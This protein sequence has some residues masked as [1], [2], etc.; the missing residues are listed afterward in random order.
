MAEARSQRR[1]EGRNVGAIDK[2]RAA[3]ILAECACAQA[4]VIAARYDVTTETIRNYRKLAARDAEFASLVAKK[5]ALLE[6]EWKDTAIRFLRT[7]LR[8]LEQLVDG[9]TYAPGVIREVAGAVKVVGE[10]QIVKAALSGEHAERSG[11]GQAAEEAAGDPDGSGS[12]K[13]H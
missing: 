11:E 4:S 9:A 5:T 2:G 6:S 10:L 13:V 3:T 7:G 12:G 1:N 8:K